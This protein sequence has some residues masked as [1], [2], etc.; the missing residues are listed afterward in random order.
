VLTVSHL[1]KT[2]PNGTV[3][4][5]R[6][7]LDIPRGIFGLLGPNGAGKSTFMRILATLQ[8]PD[9][10]DARLDGIDLIA[11]KPA[12][13]RLLGYLPQDFG[14]YPQLPAEQMLEH[15]AVLKGIGPRAARRRL[16]H[17]QL[18]K[19]NLR[20][21]ARKPL[22][23]FSGGMRQRFGIAQA[24]IGSPKLLIVDEPTA[25]LDPSERNR[26][27]H[28]LAR[29]S[30]E[31]VVLLSTHIV[32]DVDELCPHMAV[33]DRGRVLRRG[34]PGELRSALRGRVWR[35]R[36]PHAE[37]DEARRRMNVISTR[38]V[39]GVSEVHVLGDRKPGAAF[40]PCEPD[41]EDVY[42]AELSDAAPAGVA[43]P[44]VAAE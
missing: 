40:E 35:R 31:I 8:D 4:L 37:L 41:L 12:A 19:T 20:D 6:L 28:L 16:V 29:V 2:Y 44:P 10:G 25:G 30:E 24:M 18:E 17:E 23:T 9:S 42:F 32:K 36:L 15:I 33:M 1:R 27:H 39:E 14:V 26:F 21:A 5:E 34:T 22:G 13:R 43:A 11:D 3:A 7:S 38:L